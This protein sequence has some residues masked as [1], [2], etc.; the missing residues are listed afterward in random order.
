MLFDS[1]FAP[2]LCVLFGKTAPWKAP[3]NDDIKKIWAAV[4]P[5]E[6]RLDFTMPLGGMIWK[7][8]SQFNLHSSTEVPIN[9][10]CNPDC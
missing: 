7:L 1:I 2:H 9:Y 6:E 10:L 5:A 3:P 4:F 8:V